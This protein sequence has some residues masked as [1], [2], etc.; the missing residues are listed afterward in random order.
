MTSSTSSSPTTATAH[1]ETLRA[2][3]YHRGPFKAVNGILRGLNTLGLARCE[4]DADKLMA[5]AKDETGLSDFGDDSFIEPLRLVINGLNEEANLNPIGRYLQRT[6]LMRLLKGRLQAEDLIKRHPEI[7]ERELP[8][9][10]AV[11][12]LA[13]SG[14]TRLHRLLACD[15]RFVHLKSWESVFP[16][17]DE[18]AFEAREQ[19]KVDPRITSLE[20]ALKGVLYL[21]PQIAAVHPL[22]TFEVEE[23]LGLLQY[24]I[25]T[26]LFEVQTYLPTFAEWLMTH[27]QHAAYEYMVRLMKVIAWFR[28]DPPEK[29]WILKTPQHMQ[30]L[31][32]LMH[33]FP[34]AKILCPHRDPVKVVGS[35]C[36]MTWNSIVRDTDNVSAH[37][38]GQEWLE[39][40]R[41]M[42]EKTLSVREQIPQNQQYDLLYADISA[43]WEAAIGGVYDFLGM[44]FSDQARQG[45]Q[46]WLDGNV[47]HK[48]GAHKYDLRDFGLTAERVEDT[49]GFY[50]ERFNIPVETKNPHLKS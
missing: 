40:T 47:Q 18:A 33:V 4:M 15:E 45:M 49:L 25:S 41:R 14:T 44:P 35:C 39:K 21:S 8:A 24:G 1:P 16:V 26:Q 20:S 2:T 6:N 17:P 9:P 29:P 36:S 43:D 19:G 7:M 11:V 50:R 23:E 28:N 5:A 13:R 38:V 48:H 42:L 3:D 32:G 31:D 22:G 34:E 12:G 27:D 10:V 30:D 46:A 37:W